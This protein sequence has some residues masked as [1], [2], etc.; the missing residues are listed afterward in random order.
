MAER[1]YSEDDGANMRFVSR[2]LGV[3]V[4][5]ALGGCIEAPV[6]V[7]VDGVGVADDC[8]D[9]DSTRWEAARVVEGGVAGDYTEVCEGAC[10]AR[11]EGDLNLS[12]ATP[13][14]LASLTCLTVVGGDL[15]VKKSQALTNLIGLE[16]LVSVGGAVEL[17]PFIERRPMSTI[18]ELLSR[19]EKRGADRRPVLVPD[20]TPGV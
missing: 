19:L 20:F 15:I 16:G 1:L 17:G 3:C 10:A 11:I 12:A 9:A 7:D 14:E 4:M 6:D 8:D 13:T 18:N 2:A 5:S